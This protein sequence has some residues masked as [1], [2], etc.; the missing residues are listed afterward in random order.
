MSFGSESSRYASNVDGIVCISPAACSPLPPG[1]TPTG[2]RFVGTPDDSCIASQVSPDTQSSPTPAILTA[3]RIQSS[4]SPGTAPM[5]VV[6]LVIRS[7]IFLTA[8]AIPRIPISNG[9]GLCGISQSGMMSLSFWTASVT[10]LSASA[11]LCA[12]WAIA[13]HIVVQSVLT[14]SITV[15]TVV[16]KPLTA[17]VNAVPALLAIVVTAVSSGVQ[18]VSFHHA[19][20]GSSTL[21]ARLDTPLTSVVQALVTLVQTVVTAV[22]SGVQM[23]PVH[24]AMSGSST[25]CAR[26]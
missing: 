25:E 12:A 14:P 20:S 9:V 10:T 15:S 2:F 8:S 18:I 24:Q 6:K 3:A 23:V 21:W 19:T 16:L 11:G 26:S 5:P 4:S 17:L 22:S 7:C 1:P 13:F